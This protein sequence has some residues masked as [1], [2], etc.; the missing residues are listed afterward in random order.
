MATK[1]KPKK[2]DRFKSGSRKQKVYA[3]FVEKGADYAFTLGRKLQ[4]KDGTLRTWFA[5]WERES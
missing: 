5:T 2:A 4:L 1:A 3:L